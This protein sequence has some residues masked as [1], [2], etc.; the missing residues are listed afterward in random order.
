MTAKPTS[1]TFQFRIEFRP[2]LASRTLGGADDSA[3]VR[4]VA[5]LIQRID[6]L[7]ATSRQAL[8]P[9][10]RFTYQKG[11]FGKVVF[12]DPRQPRSAREGEE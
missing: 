6:N 9:S 5:K 12:V 1:R 7:P 4:A 2:S 8:Q 10:P 3:Q 11:Q